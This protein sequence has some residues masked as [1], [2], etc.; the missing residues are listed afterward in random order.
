MDWRNNMYLNEEEIIDINETKSQIEA[1]LKSEY[2]TLRSGSD[3]SGYEILTAN[4]Y[5]AKIAEWVNVQLVKI[6]IKKND[7]AKLEAK[8]I[9]ESKLKALGLNLEDLKA[10]GL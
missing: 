3:E 2:P 4:E 6:Q 10:L 1:R 7:L 8:E 9:A 5:D